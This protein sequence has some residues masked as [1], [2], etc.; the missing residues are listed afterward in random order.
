MEK[1]RKHAGLYGDK[2]EFFGAMAATVTHDKERNYALEN[3]FYVIESSREDVKVIKPASE[4][5]VW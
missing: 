1:L 4:P 5:R 3:G 2:R